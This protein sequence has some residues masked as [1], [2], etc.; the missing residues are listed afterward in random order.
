MSAIDKVSP[1]VPTTDAHDATSTQK[2]NPIPITSFSCPQI[3]VGD[4]RSTCFAALVCR[5]RRVEGR[6]GSV[7]IALFLP[8]TCSLG[9][10]ILT[11]PRHRHQF[12]LTIARRGTARTVVPAQVPGTR[13]PGNTT[14]EHLVLFGRGG[15]I[16]RPPQISPPADFP[17][18]KSAICS[19]FGCPPGR[20]G[21][22]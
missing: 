19:V 9:N 13:R 10:G 4:A 5:L 17:C 6:Y 16:E 21:K 15:T 20:G 3:P 12:A 2:D 1:L 8:R 7:S 14:R 18:H 22:L 11:H